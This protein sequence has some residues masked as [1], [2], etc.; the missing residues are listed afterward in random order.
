MS[1]MARAVKL[2]NQRRGHRQTVLSHIGTTPL[3]N[4]PP[5]GIVDIPG[6][7]ILSIVDRR[8]A[9]N[10]ERFHEM[11]QAVLSVPDISCE[12]CARTVTNALTPLAGVENV[13]VDIPSKSVTV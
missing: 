1:K 5:G 10:A 3:H 11:S 9:G 2:A 8:C 12:H 7:G 4:L 6:G 13:S